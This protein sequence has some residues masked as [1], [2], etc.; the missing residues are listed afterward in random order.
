MDRPQNEAEMEEAILDY[1]ADHPQAA[2][3]IVG[4]AE[5]W[6]NE[7]Q[8]KVTVTALQHL[9]DCLTEKGV[10]EVVGENDQRCYRLKT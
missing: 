7:H 10:L 5:W 4:I 1:L 9:L 2:D 8:I 3:S 6:L